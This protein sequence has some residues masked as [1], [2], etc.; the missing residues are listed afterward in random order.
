MIQ[1]SHPY[2]TTRKTITLTRWTFVG[3]VMSL[4]F[5]TLSRFL[6][7]F[8]P[9]SKHLWISWLQSPSAVILETQKIVC[10]C[11]HYF[12]ICHEVMGLD[13]MILVLWMLSLSHFLTLLF[14]F[15]QEA[16]SFFFTFCHKGGVI[17]YLR[18]WYFFQQSLF[19]LVLHPVQHFSSCTLHIS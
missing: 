2:L 14:H 19:Q 3:K 18:Y 5:N 9:R 17:A 6:L 13:A 10:H 8:L 11:F 15:H 4:L 1:F 16:L 12:P 7:A